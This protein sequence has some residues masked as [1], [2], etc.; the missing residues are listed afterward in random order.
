MRRL[1]LAVLAGSVLVSGVWAGTIG[2][3]R[4]CPRYFVEDSA[5]TWIPIGCNICFDRLQ[6]NS[7]EARKLYD[8]WMTSFAANGGNFMRLWLSCPFLEVMPEK[9]YEFSSEAT[10]N[11]KWLVA[12]AEEL[13]IRLKFTFENFRAPGGYTDRIPEE[14]KVSFRDPVYAPYA[15]KMADVFTN[16]TCFDI[17]RAK[18]RHVAEA[19]GQSD[20]LIAVELWNEINST[21]VPLEILGQWSDRMLSELGGLFPG[22][23]TLQNLGSFSEP[24]GMICYDWMA[25]QKGNAFMQAHRYLDPGA[26]MDV[27]RGPMDVLCADSIREL[28]D[29]RP[30]VPAVLAET[31]AVE[32]RHSGPSHFY[33]LDTKGLLIHDEIFAPFFAGSAGCGQ[34]WHWDHQYIHQNRLWYHF[35]RFAKAVEGLD[36]VAEDFRPFHTET[37]RVRVWGLRGRKTTVLWL[38]DKLAT[39][40]ALLENGQATPVVSKV[41]LP[42]SSSTGSYSWYLPWEDRSVTATSP[43][44]PEFTVS[45]V[46]RIPSK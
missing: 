39:R 26:A 19:V 40:E 15:K 2:V 17:Y 32:A 30:D 14:G 25:A 18:A 31:G 6:N 13:G 35:R 3:S 11:L 43:E 38:R 34:P 44:A 20:A 33:Q 5:K 10:D 46:V 37:A 28:L 9:A 23:M 41:R 36:P 8:E 24:S 29:R 42:F 27:C 21:G 4:T 22:K 12:R 1:S 7:T 16:E 45:A